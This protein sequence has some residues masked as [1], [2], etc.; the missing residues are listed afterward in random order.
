[1][2]NRKVFEML[3]SLFR[4]SGLWRHGILR[5]DWSKKLGRRRHVWYATV[6]CYDRTRIRSCFCTLFPVD[7]SYKIINTPQRNVSI[8]L[9]RLRL[10]ARNRPDASFIS[11]VPAH[12]IPVLMLLAS[13]NSCATPCIYLLTNSVLYTSFNGIPLSTWGPRRSVFLCVQ[14]S[15]NYHL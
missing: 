13:L 5:C 10:Y 4:V 14:S 9:R 11:V 12:S 3:F 1:M 7:I 2:A 15:N 6:S 8:R